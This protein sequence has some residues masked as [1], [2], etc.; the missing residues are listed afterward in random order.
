MT[1]LVKNNSSWNT[2]ICVTINKYVTS[3]MRAIHFRWLTLNVH[4][5]IRVAQ[6][7][8]Q[9]TMQKNG[10]HYLN[11]RVLRESNRGSYN[12]H[13]SQNYVVFLCEGY[14]KLAIKTNYVKQWFYRVTPYMLKLA[15]W[16]WDSKRSCDSKR[17]WGHI[18]LTCTSM[19]IHAGMN[20]GIWVCNI[21][22]LYKQFEHPRLQNPHSTVGDKCCCINF[23]V[24]QNTCTVLVTFTKL[25]CSHNIMFSQEMT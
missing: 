6:L 2:K 16:A 4:G 9:L 19:T 15:R 20:H 1:Q 23:V 5:H 21:F 10:I 14:S 17:S 8:A 25:I 11:K 18:M 3:N 12:W 24:Q 13:W 22:I 7:K